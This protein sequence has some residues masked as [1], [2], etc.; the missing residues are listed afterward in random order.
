MGEGL[1]F[2]GTS[3][4]SGLV[5]G[6]SFPEADIEAR[7]RRGVGITHSNI[8]MSAFGPIL[9]TP[10]G[11]GGDLML[12]PDPASRAVI[13][14][15]D[16]SEGTLYLG[17]FFMVDGAA[18]TC[19]PRGFLRRA[20]ETLRQEA[21]LIVMAAFE[22]EF[23]YTGIEERPGA[24]YSLDAFRRQ[25]PFGS[26]LLDAIRRCGIVPDSFL[27][28]YG[29]RQF[30]LTVNP[31][32][33][34]RAADEAVITRELTRAVAAQLGYRAVLSPMLTPDGIGNGTHVH[35][36]FWNEAGQPV[37]H[38]PAGVHGLGAVA[39]QFVSGLLHHMPAL[40]AI[41]VP[42]RA[43]YFRLT[44]GRWAPSRADLGMQDRGSALRICPVYAGTGE[45]AARQ[46]NVEYRVADA[47]ASPYL[48]LGALVWAGLEGIR[49]RRSLATVNPMPLPG[50]LDEAIGLLAACEAA[51]SWFGQEFREVYLMFKRS[52]A[53][54]LAG[55]DPAA[56]CD[57][58][59]AVY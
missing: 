40:T 43:S 44:P 23:V 51:E 33:G 57:R 53:E 16:G 7:M 49:Q 45:S 36:S 14:M 54:A 41:T 38:D 28:E 46:F 25:S 24:T 1:A 20:L 30:E 8:M 12:R 29:P 21:G 11:T 13:P 22:Q 56:V 31:A 4:L 37:T 19:C 10:F 15:A 35:L 48:A 34:L 52:E 50:S 55:L 59:A 32:E 58:Y 6:K 47:A 27:A 2:C 5:R 17:D 26:M 9:A 18:W 42:S 39:E 3:D